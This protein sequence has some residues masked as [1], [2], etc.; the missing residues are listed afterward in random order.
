MNRYLSLIF[1]SFLIP[2][3]MFGLTS[4]E[5][6][7]HYTEADVHYTMDY[8]DGW[9]IVPV[10]PEAISPFEPDEVV[11]VNEPYIELDSD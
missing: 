4:P 5:K 10:P 7:S 1:M 8:P 9:Q 3:I 6:A 2:L 11:Y